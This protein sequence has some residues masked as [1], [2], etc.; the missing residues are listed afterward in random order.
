MRAQIFMH[1][2]LI[3]QLHKRNVFMPQMMAEPHRHEYA[4]IANAVN[5]IHFQSVFHGQIALS[6]KRDE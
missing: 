2:C 3:I 1:Q 6:V 5:T 4:H